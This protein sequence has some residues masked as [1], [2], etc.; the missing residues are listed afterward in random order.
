[1]VWDSSFGNP[2][3]DLMNK[4]S[5]RF[6]ETNKK[7]GLSNDGL[8]LYL[9]TQKT[10]AKSW[11]FRY[12]SPVTHRKRDMGLGSY[13]V[14]SLA[15]ARQETLKLRLLLSQGLDPIRVRDEERAAHRQEHETPDFASFAH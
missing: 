3:G 1:M 13:P 15:K 14:V 7:P 2:W 4:L 5:A 10:G 8:G 6:V 11:I 9:K 12:A